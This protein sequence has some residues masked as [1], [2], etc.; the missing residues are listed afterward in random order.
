MRVINIFLS[1]SLQYAIIKT[2]RLKLINC[3]LVFVE[4]FT[5]GIVESTQ[6]LLG[7]AIQKLV[8]YG[9]YGNQSR[10]T[11]TEVRDTN[12]KNSRPVNEIFVNIMKVLFQIV[13]KLPFVF[14]NT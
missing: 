2:T 3:I 5:G 10:P 14:F 12:L 4:F 6:K 11:Q 9:C 8:F 1:G 13:T 7:K